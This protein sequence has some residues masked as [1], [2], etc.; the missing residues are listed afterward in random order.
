[1]PRIPRSTR[2]SLR[3][4]HHCRN[5]ADAAPKYSSKVR[6]LPFRMSQ[7]DAVKKMNLYANFT[8]S[9]G[10]VSRAWKGLTASIFGYN[11]ILPKHIQAV[12]LPAWIVDAE[13]QAN[14]WFGDSSQESTWIQLVDSCV[15]QMKFIF[16]T[17][18]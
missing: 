10:D 17:I 15:D 7:E 11:S 12:Y 9:I 8:L 5:F 13:V 14:A 1:L 6:A 16:K 18:I 3:Q 4:V 2:A